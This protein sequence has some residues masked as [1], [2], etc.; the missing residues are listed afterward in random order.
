MCICVYIFTHTLMHVHIHTHTHAYTRIQTVAQPHAYIHIHT[1]T[2]RYPQPHAHMHTT[3][4]FIGTY[5]PPHVCMYH[6][7]HITLSLERNLMHACIQTQ[8]QTQ[9][10]TRTLYLLHHRQVDS[11]RPLPPLTGSAPPMFVRVCVQ[12]KSICCVCVSALA[13]TIEDRI[14]LHIAPAY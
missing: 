12:V 10:Q 13:R 8:T 9:T 14:T 7:P 11:S 4:L 6:P 1:Y 3:R 2:H 5:P